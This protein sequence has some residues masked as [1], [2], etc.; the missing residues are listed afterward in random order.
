MDWFKDNVLNIT[1]SDLSCSLV[2]DMQVASFMLNLDDPVPCS[3]F[4]V[5]FSW[6]FVFEIYSISHFESWFCSVLSFLQ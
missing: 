2:F 5:P 4:E 1:G 6:C 3:P